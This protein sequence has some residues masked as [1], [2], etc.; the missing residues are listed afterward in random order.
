[1]IAWYAESCLPDNQQ[2]MHGRNHAP[3]HESMTMHGRRTDQ[4][5]KDF[6]RR[7]LGH[8][9]IEKFS[10][11]NPRVKL[12]FFGVSLSSSG[13]WLPFPSNFFAHKIFFR[14]RDTFASY[15]TTDRYVLDSLRAVH[16]ASGFSFPLL[17]ILISW[18]CRNCYP[19]VFVFNFV[20]SMERLALTTFPFLPRWYHDVGVGPS[21]CNY[22]AVRGERIV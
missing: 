20:R 21:V 1:M 17:R 5:C 12:H 2:G 16:F 14:V 13:T 9:A 4:S 22:Y 18:S 6:H 19:F 15:R 7:N 3:S 11:Q 8:P 10:I